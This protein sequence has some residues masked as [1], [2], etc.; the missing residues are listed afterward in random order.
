MTIQ[1]LTCPSCGGPLEPAAG[2][3]HVTC[4]Y[5]GTALLIAS[6][7]AQRQPSA[8]APQ[9]VLA[10][11]VS[12]AANVSLTFGLLAWFLLPLVGAVV[13]VIFGHTARRDIAAAGGRLIGETRALLGLALGYAQLSL[14]AL[15]I[16]GKI[17]SSIA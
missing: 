16:V 5:C 10:P 7:G 13:A 14:V 17:F 3:I 4:T 12:P 6:G 11:Q 15:A 8:P 1:R 2:A 9:V